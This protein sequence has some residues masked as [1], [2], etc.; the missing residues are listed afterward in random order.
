MNIKKYP[1]LYLNAFLL[2]FYFIIFGNLKIGPTEEIFFS[3]PDSMTFLQAGE[4]LING[5]GNEY[6]L[7]IRPFLYP[8]I[9]MI[10]YKGLGAFGLWTLHILFWLCSINLLFL[11]IRRATGS[12]AFSFTG[13]AIAALNLTFIVLTFHALSEVTSIFFLS[14]LLYLLVQRIDERKEISFFHRLLFM[15]VV[16]TVLK[17]LFYPF[18]L[19]L[20]FIILPLFYLR[21]YLVRPINFIYLLIILVPLIF[22]LSLM[23]I[24]FGI[25]KVSDIDR[26]TLRD[27]LFAEGYE[28]INGID[29]T[30][31]L[32]RVYEMKN[33]EIIDYMLDHKSTYLSVF[34]WNLKENCNEDAGFLKYPESYDHP[35]LRKFMNGVNHIYF[36]LYIA[37]IIPVLFLLFHFYKKKQKAH[38]ALSFIL[39]ALLYYILISSA[40]SAWQDDRLVLPALPLWIFL[41]IFTFIHLK[42]FYRER[43]G[44]SVL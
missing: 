33:P 29:R 10:F 27:F 26:I 24:K 31:A 13:A 3:T 11:S 32:K 14:L 20:V 1:I 9:L 30:T 43:K 28:R 25:L 16:L 21:K 40:I 18:V 19:A 7:L 41:Y 23:K 38:F 15:L 35:V 36:G 37:F 12:L 44:A 34:L 42:K 2:L 6:S 4:Y 22:Q 17:P 39:S 8:M 5:D